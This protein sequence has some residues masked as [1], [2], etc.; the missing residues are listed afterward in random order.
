MI[1]ENNFT[2]ENRVYHQFMIR[3][4]DYIVLKVIV[5]IDTDKYI[6]TNFLVVENKYSEISP[7]IETYLASIAILN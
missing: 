7:M 6:D 1:S 5:E 2:F 4:D 3:S